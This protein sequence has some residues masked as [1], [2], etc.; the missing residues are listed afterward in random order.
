MAVFG[1]QLV[2]T[3]ITASFLHKLSPYYSLGR[4]LVTRG[5]TRYLPP[6]D[7]TLRPHVA[8]GGTVGGKGR[9]RG[10]GIA[11][12]KGHAPLDE[13]L[14]LQKSAVFELPS[15][16]V[17][18][19]DVSLLHFS[20]LPFLVDL[21]LATLSVSLVT[22]AYFHLRPQ[23]VGS[24]FNLSCVWL[25]V[26][27]GY[28]VKM[29][30]AISRVY[31][32]SEMPRERL[33]T[34]VFATLFFVC[35]LSVLLLDEAVM[36]FGLGP[37]YLALQESLARLL[38]AVAASREFPLL[39]PQWAFK[40]AMAIFATLLSTLLIFPGFQFAE[41]HFD[42]VRF[43]RRSLLKPLLQLCY[44]SPMFS[45][46]MW[47]KPFQTGVLSSPASLQLFG[48]EVAYD[49][50]RSA[51]LAVVCLLRLLLYRTYL[52]SYLSLGR[53]RVED[54][55]KESG[56]ISVAALRKKISSIFS[57]YCGMGVQY[58]APVMLLFVSAAL[59][60]LAS[61]GR[62]T[63][64]AGTGADG[65]GNSPLLLSGF[66][67]RLFHGCISFTCWWLCF[68]HF[69]ASGFGAVLRAYL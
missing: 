27:A 9:R 46:A 45:L 32:S 61:R 53:L 41:M 60:F 42:A 25:L 55:R 38:D 59:L 19:R 6:S 30:A 40:V 17:S 63:D 50:F 13:S 67:L 33:T 54:M 31:V 12:G 7:A 20:E 4:W 69:V 44:V 1:V 52:Q 66:G 26:L 47:I 39:P 43:S 22:A 65:E 37:T 35:A 10:Q 57:F 36:D 58:V 34:I 16:A 21:A 24:E 49:T 23:A 15:M 28:S 62:G 18:S 14:T 56:R 48:T 64:A 5:L 11:E 29:L 3:M 2:V 8:T 51:V 68:V